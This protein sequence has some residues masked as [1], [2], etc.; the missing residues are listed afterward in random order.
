M[1]SR[2]DRNVFDKRRD[3]DIKREAVLHIAAEMFN[4]RGYAATSLDEIA[5][6]FGISKT[7]LYYYV[8]SKPALLQMCYELTLNLCEQVMQEVLASDA[9]GIEKIETYFRGV[10]SGV[11]KTGP[12]AI[13]HEFAILPGEAYDHIHRRARLLDSNLAGIIEEGIADGSIAAVPPKLTELILMG[14]NNW[15]QRWFNPEGEKSVEEVADC[16]VFLFVN[17]LKSRPDEAD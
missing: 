14:A 7:A 3:H 17:G 8:K 1:N 11:L 9:S 15:I 10:I 16:F 13:V 5:K 6:H 12:V 4:K 2:K